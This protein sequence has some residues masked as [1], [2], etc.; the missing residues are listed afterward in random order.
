MYNTNICSIYTSILQ[1]VIQLLPIFFVET[2]TFQQ[3]NKYIFKK[4]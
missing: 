1:I 2:Y 3:K 4:V